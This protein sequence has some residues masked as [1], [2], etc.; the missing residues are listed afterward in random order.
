VVTQAP[1]FKSIA[2]AVGFA[3]SCV[4]LIIFVWVQFGGSV[5]LA[6]QGYRVR[7]VF[8]ETG[9]LVPNADVRI[10]GV[11]VGKVVSVSSEGLK[12]EVTLDLDAKFA[13]IPA[14]TRAIL[15][16]KTLLGEAYVELSTGSRSGRKLA[17]GGTIPNDQVAS[18]QQLDEVLNAFT[19]PV[20]KDFQEFLEGTGRALSGKGQDLNDAL[21][22]LDSTATE[23]ND[24]AGVLNA[25][26]SNLK[27]M[28]R[29]SGTVL[30][31]LGDRGQ[32][33]QSL[34]TRGDS[35]FRT[36]ASENRNLTKT[37]D[38]FP[39]FLTQLRATL[40]KLDGT[41]GFAKPS[42]DALKP[43][44]PL[45]RP[46]LADLTSLSGPLVSLLQRAPAVLREANVVQ[47][48]ITAFTRDLK[49]VAD[50]L[51]PAAEQLAPVI[52]VVSDYRSQLILGMADLAAILNA[53]TSANTTSD[54]LG[55]PAGSAK[56]LRQLLTLGPDTLFGQT[57]RSS[58]ERTNSYFAPGAL[59]SVGTTGETAASCAGAGAG[60]V[61]CQLQP[62]YNWGYGIGSS[63]YPHVTAAKP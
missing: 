31:A 3:L 5:P 44:T 25:Q 46:A 17:D 2:I 40:V 6:A 32:D 27:T 59:A 56:Y 41:L 61:P 36:T 51:L 16:E 45:L 47:P 20:Q 14:D 38:A 55:V 15:R 18:T 33:L 8:N 30:T 53:Q 7:A 4:G 12:S 54:A 48:Q 37:I 23:L 39:G 24:V 29:D 35:V 22:N 57:T 42:L 19:P 34:I 60:N 11:N 62:A 10:A 13:P 49:P 21:G 1:P 26:G 63:Y 50:A 52:N 43:V 28:I 58:A 9:L